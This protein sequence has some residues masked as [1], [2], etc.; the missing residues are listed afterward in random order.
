MRMTGGAK[1]F[2]IDTEQFPELI[3]K[4][5]GLDLEPEG[6]HLYTG[7]QNLNPVAICEAQQAV[8]SLACEL[9]ERFG[10]QYDDESLKDIF[11]PTYLQNPCRLHKR[12]KHLAMELDVNGYCNW[13]VIAH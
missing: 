5:R 7:S 6:L 13:K 10:K 1:P 3:E 9:I 11:F 2:G 12:S 8:I 4:M